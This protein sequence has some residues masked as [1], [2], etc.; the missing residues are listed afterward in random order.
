MF[1]YRL[2][3][4]FIEKYSHLPKQGSDEWK[5]L[6]L[7]FIG[8]S[9]IA[10]VIKKN[11]HKTPNKLVLEKLGFDKFTGN[12]ITHWGNVFEEIIRQHCEQVFNCTIMETGSIPY[13]HG[14]LSYSPDGLSV[15]PT[16]SLLNRLENVDG[17]DK[18]CPA[19]L[20]L[21]E[22][23]CPHTRVPTS[24]VPEYYLPQVSIGM[25]IIDIME[26]AIFVQATFRRCAFDDLAYNAKYNGYGHFKKADVSKPPIE[27]GFMVIYVDEH[28]D[29][30]NSLI[31]CINNTQQNKSE[32]DM[33][34]IG[35][36]YD[37]EL[38]EEILG[39]C[40]SHDFKIDYAIRETYIQSVFEKDD[41]Y[42]DLYDKSMQFRMHTMLKKKEHEHKCIIGILPFKLL[43]VHMTS[44]TKN[45]NYIEETDAFNKASKVL[46]CIDDHKNID[47]KA[48]ALK[49]IRK[50][51]L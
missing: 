40:V 39:N 36:L 4:E 18:K 42:K 17:I 24:E 37:P 51:R 38:F 26:T 5:K 31:E 19:Q 45:A 41:Y 16:L 3:N 28:S 2:L 27:C 21:F 25:N 22:F 46:Q 30:T 14:N 44:I 11:K 29:Y 8:G 6:R 33:I 9:E 13:K 20:V 48:D 10:S 43:N 12:V 35:R 32:D 23:K 7:N 49:S 15:V 50:Y 1:K 47:N 34:D